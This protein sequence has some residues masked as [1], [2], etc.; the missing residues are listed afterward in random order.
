L[1]RR[2]HLFTPT[3]GFGMNTGIEDSANL[4]WKLAAAL[5]G[6]GG[7]KLLDSY[8]I[9]RKP[10]GYRNTGASRNTHRACTM[11]GAR[12]RR[13]RWPR[14]GGRAR[15][16]VQ[17]ELCETEPFRASEDKDAVGVQLGARYDGSPIIVADGEPPP[18]VFSRNLRPIRP[19]RAPRRR[20]PHLWLDDARGIG[21][22]LFDKHR[23]RLHPVAPRSR[24]GRHRRVERAAARAACPLA[25]L[26]VTLAGSARAL[27]RDSRSSAR[28]AHRLARRPLAIRL[29]A[30]LRPRDR[31][32]KPAGHRHS[33]S[34]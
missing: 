22:S 9:E 23:S 21:S 13:A 32:L 6:W 17:P 27:C 7:P 11:R 20:A 31:L 19:E 28:P 10:I 8:E 26:D 16:R 5:Q 3:G 18:D 2:A 24:G 1:R 14:R 12:R 15:G 29:G 33:R 30:L 4:G 34:A 25:I